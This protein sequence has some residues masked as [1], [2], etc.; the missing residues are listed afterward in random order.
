[1]NQGALFG[2][3]FTGGTGTNCWSWKRL[4]NSVL[5]SVQMVYGLSGSQSASS[6]L[7]ESLIA[8]N[9]F[10]DG[11]QQLGSIGT[12][13]SLTIENNVFFR[14]TALQTYLT[15]D[16]TTRLV[17]TKNS[18]LAATYP[19]I[20]MYNY[21]WNGFV[22]MDVTNNYWGTTDESEIQAMINDVN[23][24]LAL[25]GEAVFKPFLTAPHPETPEVD[26]D[27]FPLSD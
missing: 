26:A 4:T 22:T 27:E 9:I 7:A 15:P 11:Y 16:E 20:N 1:M 24:N 25:S 2:S 3:K 17:F 19:T 8:R 23:T 21:S 13:A 5:I 14:G 12:S 18:I 6:P 10:V